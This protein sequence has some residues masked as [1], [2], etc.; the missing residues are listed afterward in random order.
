[1]V[2]NSFSICFAKILGWNKLCQV[3]HAQEIWLRAIEGCGESDGV[4][5]KAALMECHWS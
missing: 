1:M 5:V 2:E 4:L 3:C